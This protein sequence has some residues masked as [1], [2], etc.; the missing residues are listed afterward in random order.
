MS[1]GFGVYGKSG[2][3]I[4]RFDYRLTD[5]G[6]IFVKDIIV[7]NPEDCKQVAACLQKIS[8]D[9]YVALSI[10]AKSYNIT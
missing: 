2:F 3:E 10:A 5:D 9:D 4:R 7:R 8:G 6:Q 1:Q